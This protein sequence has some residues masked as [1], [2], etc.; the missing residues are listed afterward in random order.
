MLR[1]L[2]KELIAEF[3]A[4]LD[5]YCV[6]PAR[7][8]GWICIGIG[9]ARSQKITSKTFGGSMAWVGEARVPAG[10]GDDS[11]EW[12][13]ASTGSDPTR[14]WNA[15]V[16][17]LP[18]SALDALRQAMLLENLP[19]SQFDDMAWIMAQ[20]SEG[21]VGIPNNQGGTAIGLFQ[22][23][24]SNYHFYPNGENSIGNAVEEAQ[25]GIRYM[26]ANYGTAAKAKAAWIRKYHKNPKNP[27]W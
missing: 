26:R 14:R 4:D 20:E 12:T 21:V 7:D 2:D 23:Q 1:K 9:P 6:L 11:G 27:Y 22:L 19:M 8:G 17:A 18:Q 13:D 10:N 15:K 5:Q 24:P 25:G 16:Q 3:G